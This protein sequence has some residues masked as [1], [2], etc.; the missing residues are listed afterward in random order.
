MSNEETP[1]R[2]EHEGERVHELRM[3]EL[4]AGIIGLF[5]AP[6]QANQAF[7]AL[8]RLGHHP[9]EVGV[10]ITDATKE[11]FTASSPLAHP[12]Q[13][14][15]EENALHEEDARLDELEKRAVLKGAG[16]AS[17]VGALGGVLVGAGASVLLPGF[18]LWLIG[19]LAGLGAA[20]GAYV[21]GVYAVPAIEAGLGSRF[22][23]YEREVQGGKVLLHVV[24]KSPEDEQR[25]RE[26]WARIDGG[27]AKSRGPVDQGDR[28]EE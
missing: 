12:A 21:G 27:S 13:I 25:I 20:F 28:D 2:E 5:E 6:D 18:G 14:P 15:D 3:E 16:A 24:P 19:P 10:M 4:S 1:P 22:A 26:E 8:L 17:A 11:R 7:E 9:D 23:P